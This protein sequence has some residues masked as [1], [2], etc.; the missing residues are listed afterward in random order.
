[1]MAGSVLTGLLQAQKY[2][3][4]LAGEETCLHENCGAGLP[5]G[6]YG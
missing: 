1:M 4:L 3:F 2:T 5:E 6:R